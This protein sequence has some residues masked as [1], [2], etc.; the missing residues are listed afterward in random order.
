[1]RTERLRS[2]LID[3]HKSSGVFG[4]IHGVPTGRVVQEGLVVLMQMIRYFQVRMHQSNLHNATYEFYTQRKQLLDQLPCSD[5]A[6]NSVW[7]MNLKLLIMFHK[8]IDL[9]C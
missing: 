1:V 8:L 5:L 4:Q 3:S 2:R 6:V 9:S 7:T